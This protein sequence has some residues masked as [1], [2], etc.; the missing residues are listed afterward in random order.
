MS[1]P[2]E[3]SVDHNNARLVATAQFADSGPLASKIFLYSTVRGALG[4]DPG[5]PALV[6][7]T[8]N[9]PCGTIISNALVLQQAAAGGDLIAVQG[10]AL[11]ARWVNGSGAIVGEGDVSDA[12]GTGVFKVSGTTGTLLYA[13]ARAILGVTEIF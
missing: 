3:I 6:T 7:I 12:A 5:A 10:S 2:M 9:K 11:W 4:S 1:E 8:L 13:G